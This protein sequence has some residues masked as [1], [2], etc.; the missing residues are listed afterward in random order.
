MSDSIFT[1]LENSIISELGN[2]AQNGEIAIHVLESIPT[3]TAKVAGG[4]FTG[5]VT[6][7]ETSAEAVQAYKDEGL[8]AAGSVVGWGV[9]K[10]D[11]I[12][13]GGETGA[14]AGGIFG[15]ELGARGGPWGA[16]IGIYGD[17][18][19]NK[20]TV[21]PRHIYLLNSHRRLYAAAP[22]SRLFYKAVNGRVGVILK[23]RIF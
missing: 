17:T 19:F 8:A 22:L 16:V 13:A 11:A 18:S 5:I 4:I 20:T 2:M 6:A 12:T 1:Q 14:E 21:I 9:I 7:A 10:L 23:C 3:E 15:A